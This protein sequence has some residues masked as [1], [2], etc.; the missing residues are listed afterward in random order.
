MSSNSPS[1]VQQ[2]F[3][4]Y[5]PTIW[6]RAV[7]V[8]RSHFPEYGYNHT[9]ELESPSGIT[10]DHHRLKLMALLAVTSRYFERDFASN[11][12]EQHHFIVTQLQRCI[13]DPP[14][15]ALVQA[16]QLLALYE[17]GEGRTYPAWIHV[18][19]AIRMLQSS[20]ATRDQTHTTLLQASQDITHQLT[21]V[22]SRTY[23]SC[24]LLEKQ[25]SN[26]RGR[27]A[28]L[29][30]CE[31]IPQFP[32]S[33]EDFLFGPISAP[34][35]ESPAI[36]H[37]G[38]V[39]YTLVRD[40]EIQKPVFVRMLALGMNI[41]SRIHQWVALGGRRQ[42][43]MVNRDNS[44]WRPTSQWAMMREELQSWRDAHHPRQKYPETSIMAHVYL[45][46]A[47]PFVY[48]NL[49]YYLRYDHLYYQI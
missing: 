18:G 30:L 15:L 27:P 16:Y 28:L 29:S 33:D 40:L 49:V 7:V 46:Q 44:P 37:Q 25:V 6:T 1:K 10:S 26:G 36:V 42:P 5:P 41:W 47:M 9:E 48:L 23:W 3:G 2:H 21:E 19:I 35:H 43:G 13:T 12:T 24:A 34:A 39:N 11:I 32:T 45:Q 17:W 14:S 38:R 20:L 31:P 22:E 4:K 8:F